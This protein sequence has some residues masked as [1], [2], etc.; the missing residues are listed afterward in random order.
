MHLLCRRVHEGMGR[1]AAVQCC[2]SCV[3]WRSAAAAAA[4]AVDTHTGGRVLTGADTRGGAQAGLAV[5]VSGDWRTHSL[6][7]PFA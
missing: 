1:A 5:C 7:L 4:A 3:V 2:R 6:L